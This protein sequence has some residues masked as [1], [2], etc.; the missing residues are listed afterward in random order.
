[1]KKWTKALLM[2]ALS[3][4]CLFTCVGYAALS[5]TLTIQGEV[6]VTIP[7]AVF[8]A[9]ISNVQ[10]NGATIIQSPVNI[11]YPSTKVLSEVTFNGDKT[12]ITFDVLV[13]NGTQFP[14]IFNV[15][16][17]YETSDEVTGG[18]S[19]GDVKPSASLKQGEVIQPGT[20]KQFTVTLMYDPWRFSSSAT[21][22]MFYEL[23]F[24]LD[25]SDL[26][27]AVSLGLTDQFK[28]IINDDTSYNEIIGSM[29]DG[30]GGGFVG[31]VSGA[32]PEDSE[33]LARLFEG[34]LTFSV[35]NEDVPVTVII[36]QE[37]VYGS[38]ENELVLYF[39]ADSLSER[40]AYPPVYAVVFSQNADGDWIQIG[41]I[42][43]GTARVW[44]YASSDMFGTGSFS[45]N[46]WRSSAEY[47]GVAS[48]SNLST[49]MS[50]YDAQP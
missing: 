44:G 18:F 33:L 17:E 16:K 15:L 45:T 14:Q 21:R 34:K 31:N 7:D 1:M 46:Y 47:Y 13:V 9:E 30:Y 23:D 48:G 3:L 42:L 4:M 10:T 25:S 29:N 39:T 38:D 26:T 36:K 28:K 35:G 49:I 5:D 6:E 22:R 32:D 27:Q 40:G 20:S 8:I 37:K 41:D 43:A 24:V 11:G 50:A 2:I 12:T 19:Y